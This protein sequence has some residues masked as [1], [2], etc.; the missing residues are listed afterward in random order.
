M[1]L[2][3]IKSFKNA[4]KIKNLQLEIKKLVQ[5]D[6]F[7]GKYTRNENPTFPKNQQI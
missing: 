2:K 6:N 4:F 7:S 1:S 3:P 5:S